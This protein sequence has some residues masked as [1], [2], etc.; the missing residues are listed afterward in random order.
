MIPVCFLLQS[1]HNLLSDATVID[2]IEQSSNRVHSDGTLHDIC[3][4]ELFRLHMFLQDPLA[5]QKIAFYGEVE[6]CNPLGNHVKKHKLSI[7]LFTLGNIDPKFRSTLCVIHLVVA[8]PPVIDHGLDAI[9]EPFIL[10][11]KT[12]AT[13]G[14]VSS[15]NGIER[16]FKGALLAFLA[17]NLASHSIAGFKESFSFSL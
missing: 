6:L 16:T 1:L 15:V 17:D 13:D 4:G 12:L 9:M 7:L 10:D 14:I 3:D 2:Q 11:L 5:L 8:T